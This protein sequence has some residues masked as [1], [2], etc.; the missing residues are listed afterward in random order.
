MARPILII[1][2]H[3]YA[4]Y[5]EELNISRNDLDADGSGRD[6]QTGEMFRTRIGSKMKV[7]VKMLPLSETIHKRLL[8]DIG[9]AFYR[10]SVLNPATGVQETRTFYTS[11]VPYGA[12]RYDRR[13]GTTYYVGMSF[14][15]TER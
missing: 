14:S 8:T 13:T 2:N 1:N 15:M 7:D 12:Q 3:E 6:I 9:E 4:F 5:V 11:Q 10:A